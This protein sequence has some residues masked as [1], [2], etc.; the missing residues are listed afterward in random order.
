[1]CGHDTIG[2]CTALIRDELHYHQGSSVI[3]LDYTLVTGWGATLEIVVTGETE[4]R[5]LMCHLFL[6]QKC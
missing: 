2:V 6:Y 5:L 1:M 3:R 4:F